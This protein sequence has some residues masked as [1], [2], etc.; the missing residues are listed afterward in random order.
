MNDKLKLGGRFVFR[1]YEKGELKWRKES[2][3]LVVNEGLNHVLDILFA[4]A[5][6]ITTWY[7]MLLAS[8][9]VPAAADTMS[10]HSGWTEQT[11]YTEGTRQEYVDVRTA[12]TVSNTAS[13][14]TFTF[15]GSG[16]IGGAA[17]TS[18]NTKGG[19]T[20]TLLCASAFSTGDEVFSAGGTLEV[21]YEF[22][23]ADA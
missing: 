6:Q 3:N 17:L 7:V 16:T 21:T 9:P 2:K 20:G 8:T 4:G 10:S 23:A 12:Q 19:T 13:K 1:Y 22:S 18:S 14:A 15:S 5:S 11:G